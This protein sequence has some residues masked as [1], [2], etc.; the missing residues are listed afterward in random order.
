M[1]YFVHETFKI[2]GD[3]LVGF[4]SKHYSYYEK[5]NSLNRYFSLIGNN[6]PIAFYL[7][8]CD[9]LPKYE[10]DNDEIGTL[11]IFENK[12]PSLGDN[13]FFYRSSCL[14]LA[15]IENY[16]P[17]DCA[18]DLRR[19]GLN[20]YFRSSKDYIWHRT[21]DGNLIKFL[22]KRYK[23]ARDLYSERNDRRWKMVDTFKDKLMLSWFVF[24]TVTII[25]CLAISIIGF[26]KIR[27]LAWFYH[28]P[29]C[30]GFLITY[31]ILSIRNLFKFGNFFQRRIINATRG[32]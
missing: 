18:E 6:D 13:G 17:M 10:N 31:G 16:Y 30:L 15:N 11:L 32:I 8:K 26:I 1:F 25:P 28:F 4:Y 24:S 9:R 14:K 3:Q 12:V 5:D 22:T 29:V 19:I 2:F 23:Y 20:K 27:D 21:T 7:D